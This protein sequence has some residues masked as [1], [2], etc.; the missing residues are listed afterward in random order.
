MIK[1]TY[2]LATDPDD[3]EVGI[4]WLNFSDTNKDLQCYL[5]NYPKDQFHHF[6]THVAAAYIEGR[7]DGVYNSYTIFERIVKENEIMN[8]KFMTDCSHDAFTLESK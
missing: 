4:I 5:P 8:E 3:I 2:E 6:I 1:V 7:S